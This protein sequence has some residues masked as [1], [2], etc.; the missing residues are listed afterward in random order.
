MFSAFKEAWQTFKGPSARDLGREIRNY[1]DDRY[2]YGAHVATS[3]L[4]MELILRASQRGERHI[5]VE[6]LVPA[7]DKILGELKEKV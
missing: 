2:H 4:V 7:R 5:R 1:Y 3:L 6:D